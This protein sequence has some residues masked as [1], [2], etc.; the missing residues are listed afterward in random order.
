MNSSL[1]QKKTHYIIEVTELN[2]KRNNIFVDNFNLLWN[3]S[4]VSDVFVF[5]KISVCLCAHRCVCVCET[6]DVCSTTDQPVLLRKW[7]WQSGNATRCFCMDWQQRWGGR[8]GLDAPSAHCLLTLMRSI[9]F[10]FCYIFQSLFLL[11]CVCV[12]MYMNI[13]VW[14]CVCVCVCECVCVR[15]CVRV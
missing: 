6:T 13:C 8:V 9:A 10:L 1:P 5:F 15:M 12:Y 14:V 3:N 7:M 11:L 4:R 2:L